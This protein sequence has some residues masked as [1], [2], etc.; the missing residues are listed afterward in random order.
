[1]D[2]E[3]CHHH[4]E[5]DKSSP[6]RHHVKSRESHVFRADLNGQEI[7]S[8]TRERRIGQHEEDHE[9][10]VHGQQREV[11]FGCHHTARRSVRRQ[12]P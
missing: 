11:V 4:Q 12:K 8:K 5:C 10:A 1:M 3:S 2:E 6:E 7:V 9:G